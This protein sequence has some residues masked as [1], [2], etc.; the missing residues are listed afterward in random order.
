MS[1]SFFQWAFY[2]LIPVTAVFAFIGKPPSARRAGYPPEFFSLRRRFL[3]AWYACVAVDWFHGPYLYDLYCETH[4]LSKRRIGILYVVG[5]GVPTLAGPL[6]GIL[7]DRFGRRRCCLAYCGFYFVTSAL[8]HVSSFPLLLIGRICNG[9]AIQILFSTFE[10][11]LVHAHH[12]LGLP[13]AALDNIFALMWFGNYLVAVLAGVLAQVLADHTPE[14]RIDVPGHPSIQLGGYTAPFDAALL[15]CLLGA[16]LVWLWDDHLGKGAPKS[17]AISKEQSP[18]SNSG[19][20]AISFRSAL[21]RP[22]VLLCGAILFGV[23]S[24]MNVFIF[25]WTDALKEDDRPFTHHGFVFASFMMCSMIGST[26]YSLV[27]YSAERLLLAT[28]IILTL[29]WVIISSA[30]HIVAEFRTPLIFA[31]F[32]LLEACFGTYFPVMSTLKSI[33]VPE[34]SRSFVYSAYRAPMNLVVT[35][36][37]F[38]DLPFAPASVGSV[39]LAVVAGSAAAALTRVR[40]KSADFSAAGSNSTFLDSSDVQVELEPSFSSNSY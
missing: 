10:S 2:A 24:T 25:H 36:L 34:G 9:I 27:P 15:C 11:W 35:I 38:L 29:I 12:S 33:I 30:R 1:I 40:F 18:F 22:G 17:S 19:E 4:G 37:L 6:W 26:I 13:P 7:A 3:L 31:S 32:L 39:V 20:V 21:A 5:T 14:F 16:F 23:E 8:A 28:S